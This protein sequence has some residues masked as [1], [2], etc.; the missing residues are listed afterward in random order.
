MKTVVYVKNERARFARF[1]AEKGGR[2]IGAANVS[3]PRDLQS[4]PT[5]YRPQPIDF[6]NTPV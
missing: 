6:Q 4:T 3:G 1:W 2:V 5:E